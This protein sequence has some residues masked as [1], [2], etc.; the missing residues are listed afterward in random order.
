MIDDLHHADDFFFL[1]VLSDD[2]DSDGDT[3][4]GVWVVRPILAVDFTVEKVRPL[5]A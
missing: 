3:V 1:P 2:L 4:H 5:D